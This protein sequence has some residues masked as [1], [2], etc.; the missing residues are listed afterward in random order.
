MKKDGSIRTTV[1]VRMDIWNKICQSAERC[2]KKPE[3]LMII[4]IEK[5]TEVLSSSNELSPTAIKYQDPYPDWHK[6][7]I[8]FSK[9]QFDRFL[10][11]KKAHRFSLSLILAMGL[12]K[13][14][15]DDFS[16]EFLDSYPSYSYEKH[17]YN[18]EN[19]RIYI[20]TWIK[21]SENTKKPPS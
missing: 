17:V 16:E 14:E 9:C 2:G 21:E 15:E 18:D 6:P 8:T 1:N 19:K 12:E 4:L 7:H 3:E 10:D 20:F 11:I 13:F 5:M